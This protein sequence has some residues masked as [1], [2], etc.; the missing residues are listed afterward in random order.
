MTSDLELSILTE[1][2]RNFSSDVNENINALSNFLNQ[3]PSVYLSST[4]KQIKL[5][6]LRKETIN[7]F[8]KL[9]ET[10]ASSTVHSMV[11]D[12]NDKAWLKYF[13]LEE[14]QSHQTKIKRIAHELRIF[15]DEVS[16]KTFV[17][18]AFLMNTLYSDE[19]LDIFQFRNFVVVT[20]I[21]DRTQFN[22][23]NVFLCQKLLDL[24]GDHKE[25]RNSYMDRIM[26]LQRHLRHGPGRFSTLIQGKRLHSSKASA[27]KYRHSNYNNKDT[28]KER[29]Y[30]QENALPTIK[31]ITF[32]ERHYQREKTY[33]GPV[34]S[35]TLDLNEK[36][37]KQQFSFARMYALVI[38]LKYFVSCTCDSVDHFFK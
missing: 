7:M 26:T 24:L 30:Q 8:A 11:S 27:P 6:L 22:L 9:N 34:R 29:Q 13:T 31:Y 5:P 14:I 35:S 38:M 19:T 15:G 16:G 1:N 2:F 37:P 25:Y 23:V 28:S 3:N 18:Y 20:I 4:S 12:V 36:T 17:S 32:K 21:T 10:F 33:Q